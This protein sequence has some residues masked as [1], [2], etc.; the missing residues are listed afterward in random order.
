[1]DTMTQQREAL[2][3]ATD[4]TENTN[5]LA[6]RARGIMRLMIVRSRGTTALLI[7]TIF[8]LIG[9]IGTV[10]FFGFLKK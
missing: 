9:A 5:S 10:V 2:L 8:I 3:R 4:K 6:G 1:M 7:F